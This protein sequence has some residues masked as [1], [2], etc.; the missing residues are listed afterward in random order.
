MI[1]G[2][3]DGSL[4]QVVTGRLA[5]LAR[6][7]AQVE[8]VVDDL[9]RHANVRRRTGAVPERAISGAFPMIAPISA[10]PANSDAVFP[11]MRRSYSS[12]D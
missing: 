2:K 11:K 4:R 8:H 9:E 10:D 6:A 5:E 1:V 12:R 3:R 7:F